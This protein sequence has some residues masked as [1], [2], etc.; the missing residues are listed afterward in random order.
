MERNA[1]HTQ[2]AVCGSAQTALP[3][4]E[5]KA[6]KRPPWKKRDLWRRI[7]R[8]RHIYLMLLP[9]ILFYIIYCHIIKKFRCSS[10]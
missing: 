8:S 3:A 6:G 7:V 10:K 4:S 2:S 5:E 1:E 9:V